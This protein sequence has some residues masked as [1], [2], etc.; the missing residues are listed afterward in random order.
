[1]QPSKGCGATGAV[2]DCSTAVEVA[3]DQR[4]CGEELR[5]PSAWSLKCRDEVVQAAKVAPA[6]GRA[7]ADRVRVE[8]PQPRHDLS[9]CELQLA[10]SITIA[11]KG[12]LR[13]FVCV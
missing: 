4:N 5:Q 6:A 7:A 8:F 1:M 12:K 9:K 13:T 2:A 3:V 11:L 10:G